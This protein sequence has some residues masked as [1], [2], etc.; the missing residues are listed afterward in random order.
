MKHFAPLLLVPAVFF[1]FAGCTDSTLKE[2][3]LEDSYLD[4]APTG[5]VDAAYDAYR[6]GDYRAARA[7][8]EP[9]ARDYFRPRHLEAAYVAGLSA[10]A[11]GD[12]GHAE[13]LL[14]Q[15]LA[16]DNPSLAADAGAQLGLVYSQQGRYTSA[17]E[18]LLWAAEKQSG[19]DKA[20]SFYYAGIAQQKLGRWSQARATLYNA[21]RHADDPATKARIHEQLATTGWTLQLGAFR[22]RDSATTAA[23]NIADR[24]SRIGL[25]LPRLV[26]ATGNGGQPLT[27]VQV[28]VFTSYQSA[29]RFRDQLQTTGVIIKPIVQ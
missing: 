1:A 17:L 15:A 9:I 27:L 7:I 20:Q 18:I 21:M 5:S 25:G 19:E 2:T 11:L 4:R 24:S 10:N 26:D 14:R 16:T 28:G 13:R 12:T 3:Y 8:A 23:Q 6:M 29:A 22:Q